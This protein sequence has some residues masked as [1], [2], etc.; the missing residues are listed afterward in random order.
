MN[1]HQ[2]LRQI[3]IAL[4]LFA[5]WAVS[6]RAE[7]WP[8]YQH[9]NRRSG[10]T[11]EKLDLPLHEAWRFI[12]SA[13][14]QPAWPPPARIDFAARTNK[15][16]A[17]RTT[18]D[19]AF[20]VAV[21]GDLVFFGS[22]GDD[23]VYA[24][25]AQTGEERWSF[26]TGG[27][28]RL[29]PS[30]AAGKLYFG[31]DDGWTYCLNA[32]DGTLLWKHR[33]AA[34]DRRIPGNGR[35]I[36]VYPQRTGVLLQNGIAYFCAG[37]LPM[38]GVFVSA[39]DAATGALRWEHKVNPETFAREV[40]S[41]AG[42]SSPGFS[43]QG[44][45]L[46][47][48]SKLYMPTGRTMP[49]VA[50]PATGNFLGMLGKDESKA[51]GV[52]ALLTEE[53]IIA[54]PGAGLHAYES[55]PQ[56][57]AA[58]YQGHRL[59]V[60]G[61]RAYLLS[62]DELLALDR[63]SYAAFSAEDARLRAEEKELRRALKKSK[64]DSKTKAALEKVRHA[65]EAQEENQYL[66]RTSCKATNALILA[67]DTLFCGGEGAVWAYRVSDGKRLW[68][69][70]VPGTAHGLAVSN[71]RLF[72]STDTGAIHCFSPQNANEV[73]EQSPH[74]LANT[75][76]PEPTIS[77]VRR[78][79][80]KGICLVLGDTSGDGMMG[81]ANKTEFTV[82][83]VE[84]NGET[85][86][87]IRRRLDS[88]GV[89]GSR[90]AVHHA[91]LSRLPY[92]DRMAD[93]VLVSAP[94]ERAALAEVKRLLRPY[95]G[96]AFFLRGT[97][98]NLEALRRAFGG[99]EEYS[100]TPFGDEFVAVS[101]GDLP[102]AGAW[103][104]QYGDV[105]NSGASGDTLVRGPMRLQWFG[106]PGPRLMVDRHHRA[107]PPLSNQGRLFV[108]A[109]GRI[110]AVNAYNGTPLWEKEIPDSRRIAAQRDTGNIA[111]DGNAVY[112]A[113]GETCQVL[114]T[115]TGNEGRRFQVPQLVEKESHD[116]GYV[117][118]QGD[119]LFGS[120]QKTNASYRQ[121]GLM[122]DFEIQWGD[123]KKLVT[124]V[125]LFALN[126]DTGEVQWTYRKGV[127]I[128]PTLCQSE[129]TLFFVESHHPK[130]LS[131]SNGKVAL[132]ILVGEG[133]DLV[134]LDTT[135]GAERW[136][137]PVDLQQHEHIL[138]QSYADGHLV[139]AGSGNREDRPWYYLQVYDAQNGALLWKAEHP[140]NTQGI[141]GDH[142][143]QI[144][145]P[146]ITGGIIYAE[147]VAYDLATGQ[148]VN[149]A[150]EPSEWFM[151]RRRGCGTLSASAHCLFYRDQNP[152]LHELGTAD[153]RIPLNQVSRSGC[154]INMIA[155]GGVLLV[156][157]ASSGCS[158][159]H[160]LQT[161]LAYLPVR[162]DAP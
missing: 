23:K 49:V 56:T 131:S 12:P 126:K 87:T 89:Y 33:A 31:S 107:M 96:T 146:V 112:A 82:I 62:G 99:T 41:G 119:L 13:P 20:H 75:S 105:G 25:D 117:A 46:A 137:V 17:A 55:N 84:E 88:T 122:G 35:V 43:P 38:E 129:D 29:A 90:A 6:V 130:A 132:K 69:G 81:L 138:Y 39:V 98:D 144:H 156:P 123:Y 124:S 162:N 36:S 128:H 103:T 113:S 155:A 104:H 28:V 71:G 110:M 120:G 72:V 118:V 143:E 135:T 150:G 68:R 14:P 149:P 100:F 161:S 61:N 58:V 1:F 142:G 116:W 76:L 108:P 140:N 101:C 47:D 91:P 151:A 125:Y 83:G 45:M 134:A 52:F 11:A 67:G 18:Y 37:L 153:R 95:G 8:T 53:G 50:D 21:A 15:P 65:L 2:C 92:T 27:P 136:R 40:W 64:G 97:F 74:V 106:A 66:W 79:N 4:S 59:V 80:Q 54:G 111:I 154:W 121:I 51:G 73:L 152:A 24:L 85:V 60:Q 10:V 78:R 109:D 7:D 159:A 42:N 34:E 9:D 158:C 133:A 26:F 141:G 139:I 94:L 44:Y 147:P 86:E 127:V 148:R 3:G 115:H 114:E 160:P 19:R 57:R 5:L 93:A 77:W 30:V 157:E 145:R 32:Q 48:P 102:G 16:L 22:S 63:T 70:R